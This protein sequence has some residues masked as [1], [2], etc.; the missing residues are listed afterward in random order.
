M[1]GCPAFHLIGEGVFGESSI[2]AGNARRDPILWDCDSKC[3]SE[4]THSVTLHR[5]TENNCGVY[6]LKEGN[7]LPRP[8]GDGAP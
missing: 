7:W 8:D 5:R 1:S 4:T 2:E 3:T 6:W